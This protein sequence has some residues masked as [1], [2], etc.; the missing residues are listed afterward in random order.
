[1]SERYDVAVIGAGM[2]GLATARSVH[3]RVPDRSVVILEKED[4]VASHQS[5][6]NSGVVHSGVYYRPGSLKARLCLEGRT[7]LLEFAARE[8]LRCVR[9]GKVI[10]AS[11]AEEIPAL[12]TIEERARSNGVASVRRLTP[13]A[14]H[15]RLPE[16]VG[17]AAL[18]VPSAAIIDYRE[19]A[20]RLRAELTA[21]GA[22]IRL[23]SGVRSA[24][25]RNDIWVLDTPAGE[26][27]ARYVINC[28]GLE[29]DLVA[30]AM[31]V[32]PPVTIV[33]FRGDFYHLGERLRSRIPCLVYPV[34]DPDVPFLGV[35][36]TPTVDGELLAGPNAAL[37]LAR[38]GYRRGQWTLSQLSR[39]AMFSGTIGL[40]RRYGMYAARE[41]LSSWS[42]AE[43]LSDVRTLWPVV[44]ASD[45]VGRSSGVR[46]QAV[47]PDGSLEDDFVLVRGTQS[48][49]VLNAP[50]PAATA[51][52]AIGGKVAD[53]AGF[54]GDAPVATPSAAG[55]RS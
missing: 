30:R 15:A 48:L 19:V 36:L 4:D 53:E 37:A 22:V 10:V 9:I 28:A 12:S 29:S 13:E 18:E 20:H 47:R 17:V 8:H 7:Q 25:L 14:F 21:G 54:R 34:P 39:M 32:A 11:R 24:T 41:W 6:H 46:A 35:H 43:F 55:E 49:H 3:E 40:A 50:S 44:E 5:G 31:G 2:V 33:P 42:P 26:V 52:F 1:V 45:L 27:A 38:E 23:S 16:V 51:A